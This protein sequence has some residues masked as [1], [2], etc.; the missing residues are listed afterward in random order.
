MNAAPHK[1]RKQRALLISRGCLAQ[2]QHLRGASSSGARTKLKNMME[3]NQCP[4]PAKLVLNK[5]QNPKLESLMIQENGERGVPSGIVPPQ[6]NA[7]TPSSD[8]QTATQEDAAICQGTHLP[9]FQH[10]PHQSYPFCL[11]LQPKWRP[12]QTPV[13][14]RGGKR[15]Q[16]QYGLGWMGVGKEPSSRIVPERSEWHNPILLEYIHK[17][18]VAKKK[19][20]AAGAGVSL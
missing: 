5:K 8:R 19:V 6:R 16:R 20:S 1:P 10:I 7:A 15:V 18:T 9:S 12:L 2:R 17:S 4:L 3:V 14:D 13:I 11:Q